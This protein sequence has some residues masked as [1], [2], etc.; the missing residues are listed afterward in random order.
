MKRSK[1]HP[2]S[3]TALRIFSSLRTGRDATLLNNK[4]LYVFLVRKLEADKTRIRGMLRDAFNTFH[5]VLTNF[6][7]L[8][9]LSFSV[10]A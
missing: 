6:A 9:V 10:A 8:A 3:L 2:I 1:C 7:Q 5:S 4:L